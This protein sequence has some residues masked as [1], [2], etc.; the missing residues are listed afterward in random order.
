MTED[1][2]KKRIAAIEALQQAFD[3][4][5][6][7]LDKDLLAVLL[8]NAESIMAN[9][10]TLSLLLGKFDNQYHVPVLQQFGLDILTIKTLN[11]GYFQGAIGET[12]GGRMV[13]DVLFENVAQ[14]VEKLLTDRFGITP[15]G[16]II[17]HGLFDL[18][19]RDTT[20]RRQIQQFAYG[21]K[22]SGVGLER[23]KKTLKA[24]IAGDETAASPAVPARGVWSRHYNV[25][26][27]DVYQQADRVAQQAFA[28]GLNMTAFLY[29][30]GKIPSSR[31]FCVVRDGRCF[32][33]SEIDKMG[34]PADKYGGYENKAT[35]YF[36]GKPKS[37][38]APFSDAGGY[39]CRHHWSAVSDRE[40]LRRR[41]DLKRVNDKL[42]VVYQ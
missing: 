3:N 28:E 34:T 9:P 15:D 20:V 2:S 32:L 5:L 31:P 25:V 42:I 12:M 36:T 27:Y 6:A 33:K 7:T 41:E 30:G 29:L 23:F 11:D 21:Q 39:S 10:K 24:F 14:R 17:S 37:N 40:A 4:R 16:E 1:E 38:Y 18:F 22:S 26:A 19:S 13:N 35:G 8:E